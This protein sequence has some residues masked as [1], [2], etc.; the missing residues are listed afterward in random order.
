MVNALI[1]AA[2]KVTRGSHD[3]QRD[4][5]D[6]GIKPRV[7]MALLSAMWSLPQHCNFI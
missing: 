2:A 3:A 1:F 6:P 7:Q 5:S 4:G